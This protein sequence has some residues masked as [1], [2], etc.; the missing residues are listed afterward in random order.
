MNEI[1][2]YI[3]R[4]GNT[5][6]IT[7]NGRIRIYS[8]LSGC[9]TVT[10]ELPCSI[11]FS[12]GMAVVRRELSELLSQLEGCKIFVAAKISGQL[13]YLLE[14]RGFQSYEADGVPENYLDSILTNVIEEASEQNT[15]L[16]GKSTVTLLQKTDQDGTYSINLR[17][18]LA[19]DPLTSSKKLLRPILQERDFK[20]L[21]V[22]CDHIPRWFETELGSLGLSFTVEKLSVNEYQ[23]TITL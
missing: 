18:A 22:L 14:S 11:N 21:E 5:S 10:S 7:E 8:K 13:Y 17:K 4:N 2:V 16:Q 9:W 15:S 3:D 23:V 1:A 12:S 20:V 6:S 19:M